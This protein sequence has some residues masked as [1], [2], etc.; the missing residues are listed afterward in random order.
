MIPT[1]IIVSERTLDDHGDPFPGAQVFHDHLKIH[2]KQI[3]MVMKNLRSMF[4]E[5]EFELVRES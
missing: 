2:P 5:T 1:K 3:D 4:P